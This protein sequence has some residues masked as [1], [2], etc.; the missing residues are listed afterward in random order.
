MI[1][2]QNKKHWCD[3]KNDG[4]NYSGPY[5]PKKLDETIF[6]WDIFTL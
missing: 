1:D 2:Q 6:L 5:R 3:A 4:S